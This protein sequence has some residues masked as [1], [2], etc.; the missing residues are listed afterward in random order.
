MRVDAGLVLF[1]EE[2][3]A[4]DDEQFAV[5]FEHGHIAPDLTEPAERDDANGL[6]IHLRWAGQFLGQCIIH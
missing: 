4:V 6:A 3:A 5:V 1:G 2:H